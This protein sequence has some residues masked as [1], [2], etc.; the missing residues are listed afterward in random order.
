MEEWNIIE[1][2]KVAHFGTSFVKTCKAEYADML[3]GQLAG[4]D[5]QLRQEGWEKVD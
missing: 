3:K 1:Q 5:R 4:V 2:D